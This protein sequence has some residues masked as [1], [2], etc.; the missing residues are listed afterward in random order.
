VEAELNG[1]RLTSNGQQF[2]AVGY[3]ALAHR[4]RDQ[5]HT[6]RPDVLLPRPST[7]FPTASTTG[8]ADR[9]EQLRDAIVRKNELFFHRWRPQNFTYLFGFR[10]HEQ[11]NN[12][13]E[14]PQ[15]D[16]LI[17]EL[18]QSIVTLRGAE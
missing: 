8:S 5:V 4:L 1:E 12:A 3:W 2:T 17:D 15:F 14:I 9:L 16:P 11:G 7:P 10:K 18:E 13:V 6:T